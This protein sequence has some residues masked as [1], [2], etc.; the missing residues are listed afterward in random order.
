MADKQKEKYLGTTL[1]FRRNAAD[2][3]Q[4]SIDLVL[5]IIAWQTSYV[6]LFENQQKHR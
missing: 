2:H 5:V 3:R 6:M 4:S 1:S